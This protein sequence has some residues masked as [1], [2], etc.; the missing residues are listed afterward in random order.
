MILSKIVLVL[1]WYLNYFE[2]SNLGK[3]FGNLLSIQTW[4]TNNSKFAKLYSRFWQ[5][6]FSCI[7]LISGSVTCFD[8][9]EF[10]RIGSVFEGLWPMKKNFTALKHA[11]FRE[12]PI[13]TLNVWWISLQFTSSSGWSSMKITFQLPWE[14]VCALDTLYQLCI[15]IYVY[16]HQY[17]CPYLHIYCISTIHL[18]R[19]HPRPPAPRPSAVATQR[20]AAACTREAVGV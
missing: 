10:V 11:V 16:I 4:K 13:C 15:H 20:I 9:F 2:Q 7:L 19:F 18:P 6:L 1:K 12:I 8:D 5:Y 17:L 14:W 3:I